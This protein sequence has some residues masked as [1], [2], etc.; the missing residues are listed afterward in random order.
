MVCQ[1]GKK[2]KINGEREGGW[3]GRKEVRK[4]GELVSGLSHGKAEK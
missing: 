1:L 2:E 4:E 3:K